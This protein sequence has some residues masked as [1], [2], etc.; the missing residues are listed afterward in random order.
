M[1]SSKKIDFAAGVYLSEAQK[2]IASPPP[3]HT[4]S[5]P[6][7]GAC[8]QKAVRR[9]KCRQKSLPFCHP[10]RPLITSLFSFFSLKLFDF[11]SAAFP[12]LFP[13]MQQSRSGRSWC[14]AQNKATAAHTL[15][16]CIQFT[17]SHREVGGVEPERRGKGQNRRPQI[18]K[19]G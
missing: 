3:L 17:Y 14:T 13:A 7:P 15:F 11:S 9:S 5:V 12:H 4:V 1:S 6:Q 2:P 19:L 8:A 16:T 10:P 18:P